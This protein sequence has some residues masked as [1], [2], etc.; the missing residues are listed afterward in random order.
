MFEPLL[1]D[2]P[3][4]PDYR[5]SLFDCYRYLGMCDRQR[6]DAVALSSDRKTLAFCEESARLFPEDQSWQVRVA[7]LY[8]EL[9]HCQVVMGRLPDAE[10]CFKK[11]L[12]LREVL[13][14]QDPS[15]EGH[16]H[17][18]AIVANNLGEL[19]RA[20]GRFAEAEDTYRKAAATFER[21][22]ARSPDDPWR[23][24]KT[25]TVACNRAGLLLAAG[26]YHEAT[27]LL[28]PQI[29]RLEPFARKEPR[30]LANIALSGALAA[31]AEALYLGGARAEA[32][33]DWQRIVEVAE[34][35]GHH[36]RRA[37]ALACLGK[38]QEATAYAAADGPPA[39]LF[40]RA[41][42][43]AACARVEAD[44]PRLSPTEQARRSQQDTDRAWALLHK[45]HTAGALNDPDMVFNLRYQMD[46]EM[47]RARPEFEALLR[48]LER[49]QREK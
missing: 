35:M 37:W 36:E 44:D 31:R 22:F 43:F 40:G 27:T 8:N 12:A 17:A 39:D 9:G 3:R 25:G 23:A 4:Q 47:L 29:L 28:T 10:H 34:A 14:K 45:A 19:Q 46:F 42:V 2:N 6:H 33:R 24:H 7:G 16:Q 18:I 1:A 48:E 30:Y 26:R 32:R 41:Q 11:S 5:R 20:R 21:L 13:A 49:K 38:C 15:A